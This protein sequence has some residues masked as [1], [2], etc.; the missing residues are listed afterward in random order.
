MSK[1]LIS[2]KASGR[3][4][5]RR[6]CRLLLALTA[7]IALCAPAV[8]TASPLI[9]PPPEPTTPNGSLVV[10]VIVKHHHG[11]T[12]TT[13]DKTPSDVA[14]LIKQANPWFTEV[15]HG[16][17]QVDDTPTVGGTITVTAFDP[18]CSEAWWRQIAAIG[19]EEVR[20][21]LLIE[22][23][24]FNT[25]FYYFGK[26]TECPEGGRFSADQQFP[27]EDS[28]LLNGETSLN[29]LTHVIGHSFLLGDA[30]ATFCADA[31]GARVPL[32]FIGTGTCTH[33]PLGDAYNAMGDL[34]AFGYSSAQLDYLRWNEGRVRTIGA[35]TAPVT[36]F[37]TPLELDVAGSTQALHLVGQDVNVWLEY[38]QPLGVDNIPSVGL[39]G[40][41][42]IRAELPSSSL[43]PPNLRVEP[44]LLDMTP[45]DGDH[46]RSGAWH[47][48]LPAGGVWAN[49]RGNLSIRVNSATS[50]GASVTVQQ[51]IALKTVPDVRGLTAPAATTA[52]T[53]AGLTRG[54]IGTVF[55]PLCENL[56]KVITQSVAPGT[57]LP[58]A[59]V[60]D[61]KTGIPPAAGCPRVD[62]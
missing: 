32:N 5:R 24:N 25:V 47:P 11:G 4:S 49:P 31:S 13:P 12:S 62:Q 35:D 55:D 30:G 40:G 29:L 9:P 34:G 44:A 48:E 59:S 6:C 8:A 60:I 57:R 58:A 28:V 16:R 43:I 39:G 50:L 14:S 46:A 42:L 54:T 3:R 56:T 52:I 21:N 33:K 36:T 22:P 15:S 1:S 61:I 18:V 7:A 27:T 23:S 38:R 51:N 26:F 53:A 19:A 2:D 10:N 17:Y 37:L 45:L 20:A 41:V